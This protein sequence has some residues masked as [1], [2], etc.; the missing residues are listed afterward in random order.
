MVN[1]VSRRC[2]AQGCSKQPKYGLAGSKKGEY[3]AEHALKG[4]VNIYSNKCADNR[5]FKRS[6]Y[7]V[8]GSKKAQYCA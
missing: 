7:G 8:A 2:I 5:C 4:M 1:V 6:H 3:C